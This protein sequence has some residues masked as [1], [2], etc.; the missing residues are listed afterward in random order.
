MKRIVIFGD[1]SSPITAHL[2]DGTLREVQGR[3]DLEVVAF[4][5][6]EMSKEEK[7]RLPKFVGIQQVEVEV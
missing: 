6:K 3:P 4:C 1:S 2:L 5:V 7:D